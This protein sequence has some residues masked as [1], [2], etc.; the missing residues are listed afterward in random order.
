MTLNVQVRRGS[1][2]LAHPGEQQCQV[3]AEI[4]DVARV[5]YLLD[6][7]RY[8]ELRDAE[9]NDVL[10]AA[11]KASGGWVSDTAS[12]EA[13][14]AVAA[15]LEVDEN[16]DALNG[17]WFTHRARRD[18]VSRVL[19]ADRDRA[20]ARVEELAGEVGRRDESITAWSK[21]CRE[22]EEKNRELRIRLAEAEARLSAGP[23]SSWWLA[24]Y[25]GAEPELFAT[26]EAARELCDD[27][28]RSEAHTEGWDWIDTDADHARQV[29][30]RSLDDAVTGTAP[31]AITRLIARGGEGR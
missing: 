5:S 20:R 28:A 11:V 24:E 1:Y 30:T 15:W 2:D 3:I 17:A 22:A 10:D 13:R 9:W 12:A 21:R 8:E 18:P 25:E 6:V 29:W 23:G 26:K 4:P 7:G 31:G 27:F 16:R 14:A 19:M